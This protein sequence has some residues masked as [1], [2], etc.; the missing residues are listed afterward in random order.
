MR[1]V[2]ALITGGLIV[3][4]GLLLLNAFII[5]DDSGLLY[6][7]V[8]MLCISAAFGMLADSERSE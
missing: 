8:S 3:A 4:G 6:F 1:F 2:P 7:A 5:Q